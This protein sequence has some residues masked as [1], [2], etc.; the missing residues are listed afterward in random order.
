MKHTSIISDLQIAK[1][2]KLSIWQNYLFETKSIS[3]VWKHLIDF[4][5]Q[6]LS[7][8]FP[9]QQDHPTHP[10]RLLSL[11]TLKL[12]CLGCSC[13]CICFNLFLYLPSLAFVF[14][15]TCILFIPVGLDH[16]RPHTLS[17]P[18]CIGKEFYSYSC[19]THVAIMSS[20]I[21][22]MRAIWRIMKS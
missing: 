15:F 6:S 7:S 9:G 16:F 3:N 12:R 2:I 13:F 1:Y 8:Y 10:H 20:Q 11:S 5:Q 14:A 19:F 18:I 17:I 21:Y 22:Y 4:V